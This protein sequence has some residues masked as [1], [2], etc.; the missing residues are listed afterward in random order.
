[1]PKY[2]AFLRAIYHMKMEHL[3]RPFEAMGFSNVDTFLASGNVIFE[4][5]S[6][7][8]DV[9]ERTIEAALHETLDRE[10]A[11]FIRATDEL[12]EITQHRPFEDADLNADGHT[13]YIA[14]L[15]TEP[16][17][18]TQQNLLSFTTDVDGFHVD[19]HEVYWL[20]R[21]KQSESEFSSTVLEKTLDMPATLRNSRTVERIVAKYA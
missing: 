5:T 18:E 2:V 11:T 14:F 8:T 7:D 9:L 4:A 15:G 3:R 10:V 6:S 12:A 21:T 13:L 16:D 19:G 20:C 17:D 1:M